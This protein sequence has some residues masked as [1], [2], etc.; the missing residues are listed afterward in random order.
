MASTAHATELTNGWWLPPDASAGGWQI[1]RLFIIILIITGIA[2]VLVEGTLLVF[3][4]KYRRR[5]GGR[6]IYTHGNHA[7]EIVWTAIPTIILVWLALYGQGIWS[8]ARGAP[9]ADAMVI[10]VTGEQFAWNFHYPGPD[11]T[12]GRTSNALV[13]IVAE[14]RQRMTTANVQTVD[15]VRSCGQPLVSFS[16]GME[17]CLGELEAFL[18]ERVYR[19]RRLIRMDAKA[20]RFIR[21]LFAAY[22]AEPRLLPP[23]FV[24]R[25]GEQ[26]THRV[27]CDYMA[28]MTDRFCQDEYKRLFEPFERV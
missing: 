7:V 11:G 25:V 15:D 14:S 6:A 18:K 3:I 1:D 9:P 19:H 28:G 23:R 21:E 17:S 4:I 5:E 12:F 2:F 26:S 24:S 13:D 27:V 10:R 16:S 22:V 20:N 8:A